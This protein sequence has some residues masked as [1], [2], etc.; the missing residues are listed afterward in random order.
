MVNS[1]ARAPSETRT[2]MTSSGRTPDGSRMVNVRHWTVDFGSFYID[3][4]A[5]SMNVCPTEEPGPSFKSRLDAKTSPNSN[6]G[7]FDGLPPYSVF[8]WA[9]PPDSSPSSNFC[10]VNVYLG[11]CYIYNI[12]KLTVRYIFTFSNFLFNLIF[13]EKYLA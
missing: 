6:L 13:F 11:I 2:Y 8:C 5:I 4:I 9:K 3:L 10:L 1:N 7:S 12:N